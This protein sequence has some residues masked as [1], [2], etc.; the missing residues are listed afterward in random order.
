MSPPR[1]SKRSALGRA[2]REPGE[3]EVAVGVEAGHLRG[4]AADQRAAGFGASLGDP[5][6]DRRRDPFVELAGREIVEEQQRLRPLDDDV[7]DAHRHQVD[8]DRVVD[9]ALDR[10]LHLGAD[11]V[12]GGDQNGVG[13]AGRLEIEK[14]AEAAEL[15]VRPRT[16]GG[17]RQRLDKVDEA[18][19]RVDVDAGVG[20][21]E[22]FAGFGHRGSGT[23]GVATA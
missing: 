11:A 9:P 7:V 10:D 6:D 3:V 2:D 16:A 15:G 14:A 1:G 13:E 19:A 12:V 4:F 21:G 5:L 23:R 20:I 17:A 18:V 22:R 8:P